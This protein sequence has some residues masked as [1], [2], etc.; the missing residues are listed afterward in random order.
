M[1]RR[2]DGDV[3][4]K[5][6]QQVIAGACLLERHRRRKIKD[7]PSEAGM[8]ADPGFDR[9]GRFAPGLRYP[10][11]EH[12]QQGDLTDP[13]VQAQ[14]LQTPSPDI[15]PSRQRMVAAGEHG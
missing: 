2:H 5:M 14:H 7:Q 11:G 10:Q 8:I 6:Q 12:R 9:S 4:G 15:E 13:R 3:R 1:G